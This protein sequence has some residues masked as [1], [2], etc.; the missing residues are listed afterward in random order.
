MEL[1]ST[2]TVVSRF[3]GKML[4]GK[5][6]AWWPHPT[7]FGVAQ[8]ELLFGALHNIVIVFTCD[9]IYMNANY[10]NSTLR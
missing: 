1:T 8:R 6:V 10:Q 2:I 5:G 9:S 7:R 4:K 3:P